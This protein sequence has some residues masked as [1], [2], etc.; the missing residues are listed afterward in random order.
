VAARMHATL[1]APIRPSRKC[2]NCSLI[3]FSPFA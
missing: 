2:R 3:G 1:I